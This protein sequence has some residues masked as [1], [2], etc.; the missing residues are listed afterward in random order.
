MIV[1]MAGVA[2]SAHAVGERVA[3]DDVIVIGGN[4][5]TNQ[6]VWSEFWSRAHAKCKKWDKKNKSAV[7]INALKQ[8]DSLKSTPRGKS[9]WWVESYWRCGR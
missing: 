4:N 8:K 1:A 6:R 3:V 7:L 9:S 5:L 2:Q